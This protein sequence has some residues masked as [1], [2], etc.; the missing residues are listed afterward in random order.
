LN[1]REVIRATNPAKNMCP[2]R[3]GRA[4]K[5]LAISPTFHTVS[6]YLPDKFAPIKR[7]N[8]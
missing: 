8:I 2:I 5:A 6:R 1:G 3:Y 7:I 4:M